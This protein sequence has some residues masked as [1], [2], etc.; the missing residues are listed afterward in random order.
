M[1]ELTNVSSGYNGTA[2]VQNVSLTVPKGSVFTLVG[3]NGCGKT[4][5]LKT[6]ARLLPCLSGSIRLDGQELAS[7]PRQQLARM[8][9]VLP[10]SRNIPG[11]TV[12][13]LTLH[14]RFPYLGLSRKPRKEDRQIAE[15]A[16]EMADVLRFRNRDLRELS[17]GERQK[18]Y[19]AMVIAQDTDLILLD[20]PTTYLDIGRQFEILELIQ[21]LNK[22]GKTI[23]M[24]LHDLAHALEYSHK[25]AV[26]DKGQLL[27]IDTPQKLFESRCLDSLF[28]VTG[29]TATVHEKQHYFFIPEK[30]N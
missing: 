21:K 16:M 11:I 1:I 24:V 29:Q 18:A 28:H 10:Q 2:I 5:L 7:I 9:S 6:I 23:V 4:T 26:M 30:K 13:S 17:G 19:L 20:E 12:E 3:P 14:G 15:E 22:K 8:L 27:L 25:I